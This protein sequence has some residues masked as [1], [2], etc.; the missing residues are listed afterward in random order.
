MKQTKKMYKV[1]I[2]SFWFLLNV[3]NAPDVSSEFSKTGQMKNLVGFLFNKPNYKV[4]VEVLTQ[5]LGDHKRNAVF[6]Q[7]TAYFA[8]KFFGTL[9]CLVDE[10]SRF[11]RNRL[12]INSKFVLEKLKKLDC[13]SEELTRNLSTFTI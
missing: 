5:Y 11:V 8:S 1:K 10:N 13:T 9:E 12:F 4:S 7:V 3:K 2:I 6:R